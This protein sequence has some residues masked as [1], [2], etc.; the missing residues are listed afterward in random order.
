MR[1][2]EIYPRLPVAISLLA[3]CV[4][5]QVPIH[6]A[7]RTVL[8]KNLAVA[9]ALLLGM[10]LPAMAA[11]LWISPHPKDAVRLRSI[12]LGCTISIAGASL[13][14]A[15]LASGTVELLLRSGRMPER[16]IELLEQEERLFREVFR[17]QSGQDLVIVGVVLTL[18]AP[19]AEELLFRGILQGSLE[20]AIGHWPGILIAALAFGLLHG[21]LRFIPV[22]LL[23]LLIGYLVMRAHSLWAGVVAHGVNNLAILCLSQLFAWHPTSWNLLL[24]MAAL[25]GIGLVISLGRFRLLSENQPRIPR[26]SSDRGSRPF[27]D[28]SGDL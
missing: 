10:F 8:G 16:L 14:F 25:G 12:P 21:R 11:I 19:L 28:V 3:G 24:L 5:L 9:A 7:A 22:S 6:L 27:P 26:R 17:L 18:I 13:S 15:F 4:L 20:R 2:M 23:G 1:S